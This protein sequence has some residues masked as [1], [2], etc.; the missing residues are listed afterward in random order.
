MKQS[1]WTQKYEYNINTSLKEKFW[2]FQ[3]L[4]LVLFVFYKYLVLFQ[5]CEHN[6]KHSWKKSI[7][8]SIDITKE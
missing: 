8:K 3:E 6:I 4:F 7:K 5:K 2:S 1:L